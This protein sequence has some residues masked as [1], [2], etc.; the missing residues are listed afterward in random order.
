MRYSHWSKVKRA[1]R[2]YLAK[3]WGVSLAGYRL[4]KDGD[5]DKLGLFSGIWHYCHSCDW[6]GFTHLY[7][8][9][10]YNS[11]S[12]CDNCHTR[13]DYSPNDVTPT[14]SIAYWR[15]C[16]ALARE[17]TDNPKKR[18]WLFVKFNFL[19]LDAEGIPQNREG[20]TLQ[21]L[22]SFAVFNFYDG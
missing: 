13:N 17:R 9:W 16:W 11:H 20:K 4:D 15:I 18:K 21:E 6:F 10:S 19:G 7:D 14:F 2:R 5:T 3:N 22:E 1:I 8:P 12:L